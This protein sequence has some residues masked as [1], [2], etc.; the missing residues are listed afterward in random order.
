MPSAVGDY[1]RALKDPTSEVEGAFQRRQEQTRRATALA[2]AENVRRGYYRRG[3]QDPTSEIEGASSEGQEQT[4]RAHP[5]RCA[6]NVRRGCY[7]RALKDPTSE[8]EGAFSEGTRANLEGECISSRRYR[9][10]RIF[11]SGREGPD[12]RG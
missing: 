5:L 9:Q 2:L 12:L 3:L 8:V 1:R 4:W 11:S 7:R 6:E 10:A